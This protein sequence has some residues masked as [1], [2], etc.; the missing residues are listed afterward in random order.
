MEII[1]SI[2]F[3]A[4]CKIITSNSEPINA[5]KKNVITSTATLN[6]NLEKQQNYKSLS[7]CIGKS[8]VIAFAVDG[9]PVPSIFEVPEKLLGSNHCDLW[10]VV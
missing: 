1:I 6:L 10:K 7:I 5:F 4:H 8:S 9:K 3:A 2:P